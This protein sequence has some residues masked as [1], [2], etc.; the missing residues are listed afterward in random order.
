MYQILPEYQIRACQNWFT[1]IILDLLVNQ[2]HKIWSTENYVTLLLLLD[3]TGA[4]DWVMHK[5]LVHM[6]QVKEIPA[7]LA[8]WVHLFMIDHIATLVVADYKIKKISIQIRI[9]QSLLLFPILY[10]FYAAELL[11]ACNITEERISTSSF[12]NNIILLTYSLFMK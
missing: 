12:I 7:K 9:S 8:N 11:K 2:V 3:I 1:E 6:L 5:Q 4:Y 10:L